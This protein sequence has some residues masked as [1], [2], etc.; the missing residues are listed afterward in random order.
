MAA[1]GA[2]ARGPHPEP[3]DWGEGWGPGPDA[4]PAAEAGWEPQWDL[5]PDPRFDDLPRSGVRGPAREDPRQKGSVVAPRGGPARE[6][7]AEL[8]IVS[9]GDAA[10]PGGEGLRVV[11]D[12]VRPVSLARDHG[13]PL[14][15]PLAA[16]FPQGALRRGITVAVTGAGATSVAFALAAAATAAGSWATFLDVADLG[17]AAGAELGVALERVAVVEVPDPSSWSAAVAAVIGAVDLVVVAPR[18]RVRPGDA[19][20]L[21]AR[22][23]ERGTVLVPLAAGWPER[24]DLELRV[25]SLGWEGLE[26]GHGHLRGRRLRI[27]T[28]GRR[29]LSRPQRVEVTWPVAGAA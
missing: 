9:P 29:D 10:T 28:T 8:L 2:L 21:M 20:R 1:G 11:A 3:D 14:A 18:H 16:L 6:T 25:T 17:L 27:D 12:R 26:D 24:P 19:R 5:D 23:R 7:G 4:D 22:A 15:E 13:L